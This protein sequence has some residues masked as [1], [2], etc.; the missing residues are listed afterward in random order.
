[1]IDIILRLTFFL[2]KLSFSFSKNEIMIIIKEN[3]FQTIINETYIMQMPKEIVINNVTQIVI[4]NKYELTEPE[5]RILIIWEKPLPTCERMFYN[6]ENITYIDFSNFD[7][8]QVNTMHE[9]FRGCTNLKSI[10]FNI[11]ETPIVKNMENLFYN[12]TSL[13]SVNLSNLNTISVRTMVGMFQNCISLT[14][15]DLSS[16]DTNKVESMENMFNGAKSL[17]S[18]DLSNFSLI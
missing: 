5:N 8:S 1:M 9:M 16:F 15:L 3:G 7:G 4:K 18:L 11:L 2:I 13:E 10:K 17:I 12:C 14:T 6:L